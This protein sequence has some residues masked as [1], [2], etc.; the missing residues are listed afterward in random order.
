MRILAVIGLCVAVA[1]CRAGPALP[2]AAPAERKVATET[3]QAQVL[4]EVGATA[5]NF[6]PAVAAMEEGGECEMLPRGTTAPDETLVIL[7]FPNRQ[8]TRRN[9]SLALGPGGQLLRYNDLR[10]DLRREKTGPQTSVVIDFVTQSAIA[11]NEWPERPGK[12]V[13]GKPEQF[14][15][16]NSLG[17]PERLIQLVKSR[18][19]IL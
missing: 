8:N 5:E 2:G 12:A 16:Q 9:V 18:C 4:A 19:G 3:V 13:F 1:S 17:V 7:S 15:R 11:S 10:G 14:L 6:V